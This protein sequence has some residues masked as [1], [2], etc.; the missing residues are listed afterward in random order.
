MPTVN[1]PGVG[2]QGGSL[3]ES[4]LLSTDHFKKTAV[5]NVSRSVLYAS[6]EK[7]FAQRARGE[8][9]RLNAEVERLRTGNAPVQ[10]TAPAVA[11]ESAPQE[12]P[13]GDQ[14]AS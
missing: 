8:I 5:I 1:V 13:P 10:P 4:A 2:A 6:T 9:M 7:D 12:P 3:E 11:T 14:P